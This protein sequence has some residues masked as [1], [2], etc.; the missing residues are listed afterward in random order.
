MP[1]RVGSFQIPK[2]KSQASLKISKLQRMA[3]AALG[4][5]PLGFPWDLVLGVW[6]FQPSSWWLASENFGKKFVTETSLF[7]SS[8]SERGALIALKKQETNETNETNKT[9][10]RKLITL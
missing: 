6:D 7:L 10:T 9:M 5:E 8:I 3:S 2:P 4:I 1:D